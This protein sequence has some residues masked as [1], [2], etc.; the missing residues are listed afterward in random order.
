ME[1][2]KVARLNVKVESRPADT[3][4]AWPNIQSLLLKCCEDCSFQFYSPEYPCTCS[5]SLE[6]AMLSHRV[7]VR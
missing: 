3:Y 6:Y 1:S 4:D 7:M 5:P 2:T